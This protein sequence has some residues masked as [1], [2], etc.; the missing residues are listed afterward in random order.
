MSNLPSGIPS[1]RW[2][3]T[4][5]GSIRPPLCFFV[6]RGLWLWFWAALVLLS[7]EN[8]LVGRC[9]WEELKAFPETKTKGMDMENAVIH[10]VVVVCLSFLF[11]CLSVLPRVSA[12]T[13]LASECTH[14][15]Y[16]KVQNPVACLHMT[17]CT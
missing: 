13:R 7:V 4:G 17:C 15:C 14:R 1:L 2:G 6:G 11:V 10:C 9:L 5:C 3:N 8:G 12:L 16:V